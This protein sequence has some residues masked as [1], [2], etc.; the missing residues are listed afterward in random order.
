GVGVN[1]T[2]SYSNKNESTLVTMV[3][4]NLENQH[5]AA[6]GLSIT[7]KMAE[8]HVFVVQYFADNTIDIK[9]MINPHKHDRP[10][11]APPGSGGLFTVVGTKLENNLITGQFELSNFTDSTFSRPQQEINDILPLNQTGLYHPL[12]AT[13]RL[14]GTSK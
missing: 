12:V 1:V 2:W 3:V 14:D 7:G 6:L 8:T 13:G 9:R 5:W 4:K 11:D 10:I